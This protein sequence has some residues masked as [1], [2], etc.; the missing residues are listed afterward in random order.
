MELVRRRAGACGRNRVP[1]PRRLFEQ[2]ILLQQ[3][4]RL[5]HRR[6]ADAELRAKLLL[7]G[8]TASFGARTEGQRDLMVE[9]N[10]LTEGNG[11]GTGHLYL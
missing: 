1:T 9:R 7:C 11:G 6:A 3:A 10:A 8:K 5:T 4:Q 2:P